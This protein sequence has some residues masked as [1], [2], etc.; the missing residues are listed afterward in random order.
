MENSIVISQMGDM[1]H[2]AGA[3]MRKGDPN[4]GEGAA[5]KV[6]VSG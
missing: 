6:T 4:G 1:K 3:Y 2:L 5:I